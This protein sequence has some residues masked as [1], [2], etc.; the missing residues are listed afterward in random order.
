MTS[1]IT[2]KANVE[3]LG[4]FI[5]QRVALKLWLRLENNPCRTDDEERLF[6]SI[7]KRFDALAN[8]GDCTI[9]TTDHDDI[10]PS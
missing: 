5:K 8:L 7:T 9:Q 3:F 2:L 6:V 1:N 4:P 10:I